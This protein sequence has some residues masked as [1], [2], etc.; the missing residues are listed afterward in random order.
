MKHLQQHA[1][2]LLLSI[3]LMGLI[4]AASLSNAAAEPGA[5]AGNAGWEEMGASSDVSLAAAPHAPAAVG[6]TS[7]VSVSSTGVV[8]NGESMDPSISANGRYVA[9]ESL[10]S[11]LVSNDTNKQMD[12]F[13][14]DRVTGVT[15]RVSTATGGGQSNGESRA[16]HISADGRYVVFSSRATNLTSHDYYGQSNIYLKDRLAGTIDLISTRLDGAP[17]RCGSHDPAVSDN[18]RF[19]AFYSCDDGLTDGDNNGKFDVFVRDRRDGITRLISI[20][21]DGEPGNDVSWGPVSITGNGHEVFFSSW[22]NDLTPGDLNSTL[23]A[24]AHNWQ[25]GET[26][27]LSISTNNVQGDRDTGGGVPSADGTRVII[28]SNATT[29]VPNDTNQVKDAFLRDRAAGTME[30]ISLTPDGR[31]TFNSSGYGSAISPDGRFIAF[32]SW[33]DQLIAEDTNFVPD[34]FVY[35]VETRRTIRVSISSEGAEANNEVF[36]TMDIAL[37]GRAVAFPSQATNLVSGIDDS[38]DTWDIFVHEFA[39]CY[40]LSTEH[41]GSGAQ[42]DLAFDRSTGCEPAT[43]R[44][45]ESVTLTAAPATGWRVAGWRG[46]DN[47]GS[48]STTNTVAMPDNDHVVSVTYEVIPPTCYTLTLTHS[49]SGGNPTANPTNST[50]CAAGRYI[51]GQVVT[52]AAAPAAGH[53]VKNWSG[54]AN[55]GSTSMTNSLTMPASNHTASVT[56]EPVPAAGTYLAF[57]PAILF[58]PP[59]QPVCFPGPNEIE[60]N[61]TAAE[62]NGPLCA[63]RV[64]TGLPNDQFDVFYF[65]AASVGSIAIRMDNHTGGGVQLGLLSADFKPIVYDTDPAGGFRIDRPSMAAGR[66]YIVVF[67]K[68]PGTA[69]PYTLRADFAG[70]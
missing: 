16:A 22:A 23:D 61:N 41:T 56:Y 6:S 47:D 60:P 4:A 25:T 5:P 55:N 43:Y 8:G 65:D 31:E 29:L 10:A 68:T 1:R 34:I 20:T 26:E 40:L 27:L 52:L 37:D 63:G 48:T 28:G 2:G 50:G 54:T 21:P 42:P 35:D 11:N 64:Y 69:T 67:S 58:Q 44:S 59:P 51:A 46:T 70:R 33:S 18:G 45:G 62:A 15:E 30:R 17:D 39:P 32:H 13:V 24:F 53:R 49:G 9:F 7:I 38:N 19:V 66:Y 12:V 3:L 14:H 36:Y 57:A